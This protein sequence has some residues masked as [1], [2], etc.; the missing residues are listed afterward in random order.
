[1]LLPPY[2]TPEQQLDLRHHLEWYRDEVFFTGTENDSRR[3][4]RAGGGDDARFEE[5]WACTCRW[6]RDFVQAVE[7][8]RL[9]AARGF[10]GYYVSGRKP[11]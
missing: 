9:H 8:G 5:L 4:F 6:M 11:R 3:A 2:D 7:R 10:V 1:M